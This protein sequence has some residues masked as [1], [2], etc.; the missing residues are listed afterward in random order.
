M[1]ISETEQTQNILNKTTE[2]LR[3]KVLHDMLKMLLLKKCIH[4]K[5]VIDRITF[6]KRKLMTNIKISDNL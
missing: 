3:N 1:F 4:C 5:S 2:S 6:Y